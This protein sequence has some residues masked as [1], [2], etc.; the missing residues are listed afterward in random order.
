MSSARDPAT[1]RS[2][3]LQ[4]EPTI[5]NQNDGA[6]RTLHYQLNFIDGSGA[7]RW[8]DPVI[9]NGGST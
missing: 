9:K 1:I 6:P 4:S 3:S 8:V 7:R 2:R 5:Q